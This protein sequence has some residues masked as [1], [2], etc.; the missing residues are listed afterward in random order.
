MEVCNSFNGSDAFKMSS[1][2]LFPLENRRRALCFILMTSKIK[3]FNV[4]HMD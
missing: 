3:S 2:Q 1:D 4:I